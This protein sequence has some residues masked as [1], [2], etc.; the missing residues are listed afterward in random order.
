[1]KRIPIGIILIVAMVMAGCAGARA[2]RNVLTPAL[3]GA[4]TTIA[5]QAADGGATVELVAAFNVALET[6]AYADV[7][8]Q[9]PEIRAAAEVSI[10]AR[11][12]GGE[13]GP[14]VAESLRSR[15]RQF[16]E[17]VALLKESW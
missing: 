10:L 14:G 8:E 15:L 6:R 2:Q 4:W 7:V 3:L 1:M 12:A 11:L 13:I 9:W 17:G 5:V 16:N